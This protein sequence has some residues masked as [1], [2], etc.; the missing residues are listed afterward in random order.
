MRVS[1]MLC[2]EY[3]RPE[4]LD[5][6]RDVHALS[7]QVTRVDVCANLRPDRFAH[8]EQRWH[9]VGE[10]ERV[11]LEANPGHAVVARQCREV[12]PQRDRLVPLPFEDLE[13]FSR[14][15]IDDLVR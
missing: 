7:H 9:V 8:A 6:G 15:A 2:V 1:L 13:V 10:V 11:K 14:P 3:R 4:R 12:A 5:A